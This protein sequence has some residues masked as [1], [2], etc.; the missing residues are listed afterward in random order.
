MKEDRVRDNKG[1]DRNTEADKVFHH[2]RGFIQEK[3]RIAI[4]IM[5]LW[6]ATW[7][8]LLDKDGGRTLWRG[9]EVKG[10]GCYNHRALS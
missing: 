8:F 5:R 3:E 4:Q 6:R 1:V 7:R 9:E 10:R 2:Q